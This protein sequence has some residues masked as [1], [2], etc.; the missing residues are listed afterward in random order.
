MN[1][2]KRVRYEVV[3]LVFVPPKW[4]F[5][6]NICERIYPEQWTDEPRD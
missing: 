6:P 1:V 3:N 4:P 5:R 2:Y